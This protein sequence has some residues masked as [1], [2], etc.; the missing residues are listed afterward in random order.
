MGGLGWDFIDRVIN[1]LCVIRAMADFEYPNP[2]EGHSLMCNRA[3]RH[4]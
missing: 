3:V 4:F 2:E 1:S